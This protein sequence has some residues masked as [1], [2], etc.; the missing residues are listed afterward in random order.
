MRG[1]VEV[2]GSLGGRVGCKCIVLHIVDA[3][4]SLF[5]SDRPPQTCPPYPPSS[6]LDTLPSQER[7][8]LHGVDVT[9]SRFFA[10][11]SVLRAVE[12]AAR[13]HAGHRRRTGEPYVS[14]CIHT[15]LIVEH[16]IP[17]SVNIERYTAAVA[18]AVLHDVVDDAAVSVATLRRE[19]GDA[20][21]DNVD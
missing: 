10:D 17:P 14:H 7:V 19:F 4:G 21:A 1:W 20:V 6:T 3:P 15:G 12:F 16:N 13:A 11:P 2:C 5:F 8:V 9:G 18:A